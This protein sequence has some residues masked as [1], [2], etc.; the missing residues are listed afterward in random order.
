MYDAVLV[1]EFLANIWIQSQKVATS[2]DDQ[3]KPMMEEVDVTD[4]TELAATKAKL[5]E[6]KCAT[7]ETKCGLFKIECAKLKM[8][9]YK[10][11]TKYE[12][13]T[14]SNVSR[15]LGLETVNWLLADLHFAPCNLTFY[16]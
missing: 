13:A 5:A 14:N 6:A 16:R 2:T 8:K 9:C 15:S 10:F 4:Q 1:N 7:L 3:I 11:K 12:L